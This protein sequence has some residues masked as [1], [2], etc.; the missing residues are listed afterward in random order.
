[1]LKL[2]GCALATQFLMQTSIR[3][4][5]LAGTRTRRRSVLFSNGNRALIE[6]HIFLE[7]DMPGKKYGKKPPKK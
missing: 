7:T 3:I 4:S 6:T 1:M 5:T 2:W